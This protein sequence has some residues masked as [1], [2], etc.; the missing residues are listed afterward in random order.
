MYT[1]DEDDQIIGLDINIKE[2]DAEDEY[3]YEVLTSDQIV[4]DMVSSIRDVN[5]VV[6]LS[7]TITRLLLNHF[8]W[9]KERLYER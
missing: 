2:D 9:D 6:Q 5:T 1:D 8:K 4:E 3:T 7:P